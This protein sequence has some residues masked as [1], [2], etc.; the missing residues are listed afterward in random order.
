MCVIEGYPSG[1]IQRRFGEGVYSEKN[2]PAMAVSENIKQRK[3][4]C[5]GGDTDFRNAGLVERGRGLRV[6]FWGGVVRS[7][8]SSERGGK[9][10]EGIFPKL[11]SHCRASN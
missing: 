10:Q 4:G 2:W 3:K 6:A 7:G 5:Q 11:G 9:K 1:R 8:R